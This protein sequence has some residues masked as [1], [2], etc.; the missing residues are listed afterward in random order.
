MKRLLCV[1]YLLCLCMA[2]SH[3]G[4]SSASDRHYHLTGQVKALDPKQHTANVDA[5]AIPNFMEAMSMDYPIKSEGEFNK[6]KVGE[7]IEATINVHSDDSYD[8]S[9]IHPSEAKK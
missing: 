5:A 9:D 7:H 1:S 2:C 4:A 6:L 3:K 8:L